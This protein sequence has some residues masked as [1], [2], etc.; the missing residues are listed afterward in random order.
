MYKKITT[1]IIEEHF[2]EVPLK[3]KKAQT[4]NEEDIIKVNVPLMIRLLEWAREDAAGDVDLHV[5][6]EKLVD[7][8][9]DG[10][11]LDMKVYEEI[12][13]AATED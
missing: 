13:P 1:N 5:A 10:D 3:A 6:V 8:C 2:D 9:D 7:L 11:V 12:V 4:E